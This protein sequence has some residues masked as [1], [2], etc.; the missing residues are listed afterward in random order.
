M[1]ASPEKVLQQAKN[2]GYATV[3]TTCSFEEAT[4]LH[5][6]WKKYNDV[7]FVAKRK[8]NAAVVIVGYVK[9]PFNGNAFLQ[10]GLK[11]A[12]FSEKETMTRMYEAW[13]E[14]TKGKK[15]LRVSHMLWDI[16]RVPEA[17]VEKVIATLKEK[18]DFVP[19]NVDGVVVC[20]CPPPVV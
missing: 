20:P 10:C 9:D 6:K 13:T 5:E 4:A 19:T 15:L 17:S 2:D 7:L 16:T 14:R 12:Q 18:K 8:D 1:E 11:W 3:M